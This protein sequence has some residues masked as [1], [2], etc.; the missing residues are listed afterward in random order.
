MEHCWHEATRYCTTALMP[1]R[2]IALR[3]IIIGIIRQRSGAFRLM[4]DCTTALLHIATA[5][6][7]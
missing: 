3:P 4:Q 5:P 1:Y 7:H 2:N 6:V